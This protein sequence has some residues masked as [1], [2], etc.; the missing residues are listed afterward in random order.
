[1]KVFL[2]FLR[3]L[4][5]KSKIINK[6]ETQFSLRYNNSISLKDLEKAGLAFQPVPPEKI[7]KGCLIDASQVPVHI[8]PHISLLKKV[9]VYQITFSPEIQSQIQMGTLKLTGGVV[10]DKTGR[11]VAHGANITPAVTSVVMLYQIGVIVFGAHQL[12]KINKSLTVIQKKLDNIH[13]FQIDKRSAQISSHFKELSH[14]SKGIFECSKLGN[15]KEVLNRIDIIKYIRVKNSTNLLHLKKNLKDSLYNLNSLESSS[16]F[17]SESNTKQLMDCLEYYARDITD[18]RSALFLDIILLKTEVCFSIC[19]SFAETNSRLSDQEDHLVFFKNQQ[20]S[21]ERVLNT[22]ISELVKSKFNK[23][24]TIKQR[25]AQISQSWR[26]KKTA[27][28]DFNAKCRAEIQSIKRIIKPESNILFLR[29]S[30]PE[31]YKKTV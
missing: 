21:F 13:G 27:F 17:G 15:I 11:I 23:H 9:G 18:Y 25:R 7:K 1:M 29:K 26:L 14:I 28:P 30:A 24:E 16:Y 31:E 6:F 5:K 10:R 3:R 19:K 20:S 12:S 2:N 4:F 8:L 22:K